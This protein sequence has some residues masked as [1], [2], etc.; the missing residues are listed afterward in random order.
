MRTKVKVQG[1]VSPSTL[2]D[3]IDVYAASCE[4]LSFSEFL[5]RLLLRA[6]AEHRD[7]VRRRELASQYDGEPML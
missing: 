2:E 6:I 1:W 3:A 5:E 7:E 4:D